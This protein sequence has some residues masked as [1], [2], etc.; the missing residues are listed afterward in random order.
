MSMNSETHLV[1]TKPINIESG[2]PL[3]SIDYRLAPE[4]PYPNGLEDCWNVYSWMVNTGLSQMNLF[5]EKIVLIGDSAGGNLITSLTTICVMNN[6]RIPDLLIP[7]Y[8]VFQMTSDVLLPS[9]MFSLTDPL[10]N[11][12]FGGLVFSAY[13]G[14]DK[15]LKKSYMISPL[16]MPDEILEKFPPIRII[17]GTKDPLRDESY[18]FMERCISLKLDARLTELNHFPHGFMNYATNSNNA[19]QEKGIPTIKGHEVGISKIVSWIQE[20]SQLSVKIKAK[21]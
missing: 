9:V 11:T 16:R 1:H 5:P 17:L 15:S 19:K 4:N 6:F 7:I 12:G 21:L 14:G 3:F 13:T 20:F 8:P 10:L 2:C 18:L